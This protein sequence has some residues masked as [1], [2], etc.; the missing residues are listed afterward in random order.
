MKPPLYV[1]LHQHS[2]PFRDLFAARPLRLGIQD[3]NNVSQRVALTI[4]KRI[5]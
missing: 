1:Q 4:Y 3:W 2:Q 5:G